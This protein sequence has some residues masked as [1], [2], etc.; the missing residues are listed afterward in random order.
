M[1]Y[2][3]TPPRETES[4]QAGELATRIRAL[5]DE[6][7]R[8]YPDLTERDVRDAL[9]AAA[10]REAAPRRVGALVAGLAGLVAFGVGLA[11]FASQGGGGLVV[12]GSGVAVGVAVFVAAAL[13][14]LMRL[15]R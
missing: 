12:G 1:A 11:V 15:R 4:P 3:P 14:A 9:D 8:H 10:G 2:V 6:Y 5:I 7:R 13:V